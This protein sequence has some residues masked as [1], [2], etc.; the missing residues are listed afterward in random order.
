[1]KFQ[2]DD[3]IKIQIQTN[4]QYIPLNHDEIKKFRISSKFVFS[5]LFLIVVIFLIT[6]NVRK[7]KIQLKTILSRKSIDNEHNR[8]KFLENLKTFLDEDEIIENEMM[9]KHTT[10]E[11][12]GPAKFF[13]KPKSI[14]KSFA[15]MQRIFSRIFYI[16]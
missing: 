4:R 8:K 15:V 12:G 10:F 5:F 16:R 11:L 14:N 1:M 7:R 6:I 9:N 13:I 3:K 2:E